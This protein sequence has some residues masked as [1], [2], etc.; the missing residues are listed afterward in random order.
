MFWTKFLSFKTN[1]KDVYGMTKVGCIYLLENKTK[2]GKASLTGMA[3]EL[4]AHI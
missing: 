4:G 2:A 1:K 3:V